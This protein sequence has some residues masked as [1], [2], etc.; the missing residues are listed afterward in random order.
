MT[1]GDLRKLA[2]RQQTRIRFSLTNGME[3]VVNEQ[4]LAQVP[5]LRSIPNF[6]LEQELAAARQFHLDAVPADPKRTVAPRAVSR[7]E[8]AAMTKA[9]AGVE[10]HDREEE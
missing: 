7:D 1:L 10:N 9:P 6:N 3:C 2:I 4:G 5:A 8:L